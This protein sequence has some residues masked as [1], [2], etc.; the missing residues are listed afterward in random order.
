MRKLTGHEVCRQCQ[1]VSLTHTHG[2]LWG[3]P[4]HQTVGGK[5][6]WPASHG[7]GWRLAG[8]CPEQSTHWVVSHL[9]GLIVRTVNQGQHREPFGLFS[10]SWKSCV[11]A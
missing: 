6:R 3:Q 1:V 2:Q 8:G 11:A 5:V 4:D 7:G 9:D 10:G